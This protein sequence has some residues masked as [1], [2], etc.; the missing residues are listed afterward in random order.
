MDTKTFLS[1]S[2]PIIVSES[3]FK[4]VWHET[5]VLHDVSTVVTPV[6]SS[7]SKLL[8]DANCKVSSC[9][10]TRFERGSVVIVG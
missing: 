9:L 2:K 5:I 4:L 8:T 6:I 3:G 10:N 1:L 7:P